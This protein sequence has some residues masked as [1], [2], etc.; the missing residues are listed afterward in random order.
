MVRLQGQR[1][2]E[3]VGRLGQQLLVA[4]RRAEIDAR[5]D[6]R[7]VDRDRAAAERDR[8]VGLAALAQDAGEIGDET[9]IL[10]KL[11]VDRA[12]LAFRLFELPGVPER[13]QQLAPRRRGVGLERD[14]PAQRLDQ[15]GVALLA[16]ER[17]DATLGGRARFSGIA[18]EGPAEGGGGLAARAQLL[19]HAAQVHLR[20]DVV[21][22]EDRRPLQRRPR[23]LALAGVGAQHAEQMPGGRMI[24]RGHDEPLEPFARSRRVAAMIAGDRLVERARAHR[25]GALNPRSA[26]TAAR[27]GADQSSGR[28]CR[29]SRMVGYQGVSLRSSIHR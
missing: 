15:I 8:L 23:R 28:C 2:L 11:Q 29:N 5:L 27:I 9:E 6:V 3:R 19:Q 4:E 14:E 18:L 21:G 20:V 24:R 22:C 17:I 1:L 12:G 16:P 26:A 13:G 7:R 25:A 10:G